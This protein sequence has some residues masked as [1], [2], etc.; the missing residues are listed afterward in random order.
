MKNILLIALVLLLP[1]TAFL[2]THVAKTMTGNHGQIGFYQFTPDDYDENREEK[3]PLI[4]FLHGIGERGNGTTEIS[5]VLTNGVPKTISKGHKMK[6]FWNGRMQSFLVL[7][8]Q[9]SSGYSFWQL[10]YVDE[11]IRYAKENLNVDTNRIILTGISLGGGGSWYW[12]GTSQVNSKQLAA[13]GVGCGTCQGIDYTNI[14]KAN[15]PIWAFHANNDGTVSV[16]CTT[17]AISTI[18]NSKPNVDPYMTIWPD[19]GHS[20]WDRMY[21]TAYAWQNPNIYEWFL[22]QDKSKPINK[23]PIANAGPDLTVSTATT[24]SATL[25][26]SKSID[27]DGKI[28][29]YVWSKISGPTGGNIS[30]PVSENGLTTITGLSTTGT[31]VYQLKVVDERA[32]YTL[33]TVRINVVNTSVPNIPPIAQT[34]YPTLAETSNISLDGSNSYDPDG[35]V[36]GYEWQQLSGPTSI[37]LSGSSSS[38]ATIANLS[39]GNYKFTFTAVDNLGAATIDT[40]EFTANNQILPVRFQPLRGKAI[41]NTHELTWGIYESYEPNQ[42][43][44]EMSTDGVN[45]QVIYEITHAET[46]KISKQFVYRNQNAP[47]KAY[48]RVR[49]ISSVSGWNEITPIITI[50]SNDKI[51][52]TQWKVHPNPVIHTTSLQITSE[53]K[54]IHIV[55]VVNLAGKI[56]QSHTIQHQG[57]VYVKEL[58]L[59]SLSPGAYLIEWIE[60]SGIRQTSKIMK[61]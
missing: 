46:D 16:G 10:F 61:L 54:G 25:S 4:I 23:R 17:G 41:G 36:V 24:T 38:K 58:D 19:G 48:Y 3:Y 31:Y 44:I 42:Q 40:V 20:I 13:L 27:T 15:V 28:V 2:Q 47:S 52:S 12:A 33:D 49:A 51:N 6:F 55:R 29:R 7:S 8:P 59:S 60:P 5:R 56:I 53:I 9:L 50:F 57:G 35:L 1:F 37:T 30:T 45:F 18:R 26:G 39:N 32:D 11:M 21:D 43:M 14:S 22:G 34:N